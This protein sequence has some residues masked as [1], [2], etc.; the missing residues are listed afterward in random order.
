MTDATTTTEPTSPAD[1]ADAEPFSRADLQAFDQED[2]E[3]GANICKM[4]SLFF[5]YT[6]VAMGAMTALTYYWISQ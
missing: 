3:A 1:S 5:F 4:L 2:T 6:V